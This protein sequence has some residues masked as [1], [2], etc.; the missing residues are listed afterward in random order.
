MPPTVSKSFSPVPS[1]ALYQETH[2]IL[3]FL[4]DPIPKFFLLTHSIIAAGIPS[5]QTS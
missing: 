5:G 3:P 4:Y 2:C 1:P